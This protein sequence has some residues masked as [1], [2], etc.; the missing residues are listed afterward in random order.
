[1]KLF[2][3]TASLQLTKEI[4]KLTTHKLA[5]SLVTRFGNSE[6]KISIQEKV[7]NETCYVIQST[8]NPTDTHLME[9]FFFADAL[10]RSEV[11][12][13]IAIIPYFGYARQ[14]REHKKGE[15]VSVNVVIRFLEYIGFSEIYT[16]DLHDEGTEGIFTIPFKNLTA[17]PILAKTLKKS[18]DLKNTIVVS[19]D[20]GGVE[21]ARNFSI[22]LFEGKKSEVAVVE[23]QRDLEKIHQSKA[24]D[25]YGNVAGKTVVLV[26]DIITS[27]RTLVNAA[28]ICKLRGA[29]DIY[30]AVTHHDF[31]KDAVTILQNS[32]I[33]K[34]LTTNTIS[35]L[36]YQKFTKLEEISIAPVIADLFK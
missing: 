1:M 24:I 7:T 29:K 17:Y 22:N 5:K 11:K 8:S 3:G 21:R 4:A 13:I 2:A 35:L 27:G 36:S 18:L 20:Q 16:F 23:K 19:P 30:G 10:K 31:T 28:K 14:N 26:D 33:K 32:P 12:K 6:I 25:L 9:L 15:S 34:I